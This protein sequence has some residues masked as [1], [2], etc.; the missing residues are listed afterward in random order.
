MALTEDGKLFISNIAKA[1]A[2]QGQPLPPTV[3]D[4]YARQVYA[5]EVRNIQSGALASQPA[6]SQFL[7]K[8]VLMTI[9]DARGKGIIPK[10]ASITKWNEDN[11]TL[12]VTYELPE[13]EAEQLHRMVGGATILEPSIASIKKKYPLKS[14][15]LAISTYML[16]NHTQAD[17][18]DAYEASKQWGSIA[19]KLGIT[20][21]RPK[22]WDSFFGGS[23]IIYDKKADKYYMV[24][25]G[26]APPISPARIAT[27]ANAAKN[28][29]DTAKAVQTLTKIAPNL[30]EAQYARFL[31]RRVLNSNLTPEQF[32]RDE[33]VFNIVN[34]SLKP[35]K[36]GESIAKAL[37]DTKRASK[38]INLKKLG[39]KEG[40]QNVAVIG[41]TIPESAV[42][43]NSAIVGAI[44][45]PV[46][47]LKFTTGQIQSLSALSADSA[48][49]SLIKSNQVAIAIAQRPDLM[50]S[51][52]GRATPVYRKLLENNAGKELA[53]ALSEGNTDL[54]RS[55]ANTKVLVSGMA[56]NLSDAAKQAAGVLFKQG[57][58]TKTEVEQA[59]QYAIAETIQNDADTFLVNMTDS[60]LDNAIQT[61][62]NTSTKTKT[63]PTTTTVTPTPK[64]TPT[65]TPKPIPTPTPKPTPTPTI[66]TFTTPIPTRII[67]DGGTVKIPKPDGSGSFELTKK[68]WDSVIAWKQGFMYKMI[69]TPY[70]ED[71]IY[72]STKPIS[73]VKYYEG[74]GS[75]AKSAVAKGIPPEVIS[76]HMGIVT[77]QF[78]SSGVLDD[79]PKLVFK[80]RNVAKSKSKRKPHASV[81]IL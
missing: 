27:I 59:I 9:A 2:R 63:T 50:V 23:P 75:A 24:A 52:F 16:P 62:V 19:N 33:R 20:G 30:S 70:G 61:I 53:F 37:E 38:T 15:S 55:L 5:S 25:Y 36:Y 45:K 48:I 81:S 13:T 40:G 77:V 49:D 39:I 58:Y 47:T 28:V 76:R 32:I 4:P 68:Q 72:N 56:S 8:E 57:G 64:P 73:G 29:K 34:T 67:I 74:I 71:D 79:K 18:K 35:T 42:L 51:I 78:K 69:W 14:I 22:W 65:P 17:L 31:Q 11:G 3:V 10:D 41:S 26:D 66:S 43:G 7:S 6:Q 1:Y 54:A 46:S 44:N 12:N 21:D 60:Q 80:R